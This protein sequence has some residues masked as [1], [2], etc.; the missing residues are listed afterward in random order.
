MENV[1]LPLFYYRRHGNNLTKNI[2]R[3]LSARRQINKDAI[4][5][6]LKQYYP[7]IAVIPCRRNF[8]FVQNLWNIEIG[9]KTLLE[10]DIEVCLMSDFITKIVVTCD[11][12]EAR[13]TVESF[14]DQRIEFHLRDEKST[15]RSTSLVPT[16]REITS[17]Y[18]ENYEGITVIRYI[19][20]PFVSSKVLND[21]ISSLL[22]NEAESSYGVQLV[23]HELYRR[24]SNGLETLRRSSTSFKTDFDNIYRDAR[25]FTALKNRNLK[26]GTIKGFLT[27][28]FEVTAD[29]SFFI[30]S[31]KDI[32][33]AEFL[34]KLNEK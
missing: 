17:K 21:A 19:Q 31:I 10:R 7:V 33:V 6:K 24:T 22:I 34:L 13:K 9:G 4:N 5:E 16:L 18:D 11:N 3:I 29:E 15:I 8:D 32:E 25:T 20:T 30:N 1:N 23:D 27:S 12:F 26:F 14:N 2:V 28:C